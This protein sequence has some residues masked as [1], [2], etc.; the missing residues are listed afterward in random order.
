MNACVSTLKGIEWRELA[1]EANYS[2]DQFTYGTVI[3]V[4]KNKS[5]LWVT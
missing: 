3:L 1:W 2:F 5:P 4:E